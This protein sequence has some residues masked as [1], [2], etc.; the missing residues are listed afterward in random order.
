ML[1]HEEFAPAL[2]RR[3]NAVFA[4]LNEYA[5]TKASRDVRKLP[6]GAVTPKALM[7]DIHCS[8]ID[9]GQRRDDGC[10]ERGRRL[11]EKNDRSV[12]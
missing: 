12:R 9:V 10:V 4:S 1:C 3:T 6:R 11:V 5:V 7:S 8:E 2:Q